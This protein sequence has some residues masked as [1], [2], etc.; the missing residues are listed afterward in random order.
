[1]GI[2]WRFVMIFRHIRGAGEGR[3]PPVAAWWRQAADRVRICIH[4]YTQVR[5]ERVW[6]L[7]FQ[8]EQ[9]HEEREVASILAQKLP[10]SLLSSQILFYSLFFRR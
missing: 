7:H 10:P 3:A 2:G 6:Q 4:S 8:K 9:K 1:M 5:K